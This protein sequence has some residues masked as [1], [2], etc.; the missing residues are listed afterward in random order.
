MNWR[1]R[2]GREG[3]SLPRFLPYILCC[4]ILVKQFVIGEI[5][6]HRWGQFAISR[7][8]SDSLYILFH[9]HIPLPWLILH[10]SSFSLII[11]VH[12]FPVIGRVWV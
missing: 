9:L 5:N 6:L 10:F 8:F 11:C 4:V 2:W 3:W 7:A 12:P 1:D